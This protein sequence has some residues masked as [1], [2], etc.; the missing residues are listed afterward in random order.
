MLI[1][2]CYLHNGFKARLKEGVIYSTSS[3]SVFFISM[4][5][6]L[7]KTDIMLL[8]LKHVQQHAGCN[9]ICLCL[10]LFL[11]IAM[12]LSLQLI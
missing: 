4:G 7:I 9:L 12:Y 10:I 1:V 5:V 2:R 8:I 3:I 11:H 6:M